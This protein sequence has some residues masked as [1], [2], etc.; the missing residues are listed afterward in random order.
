MRCYRPSPLHAPPC[1]RCFELAAP[2][3]PRS[4]ATARRSSLG[5]VVCAPPGPYVAATHRARPAR[6]VSRR[7]CSAARRA[8]ALAHARQQRRSLKCMLSVLQRCAGVF[9]PREPCARARSLTHAFKC[10]QHPAHASH[11]RARTRIALGSIYVPAW[12][13]ARCDTPLA[14]L[15]SQVPQQALRH[16]LQRRMQHKHTR[17]NAYMLPRC[18]PARIQRALG[19]ETRINTSPHTTHKHPA[20][21]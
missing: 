1:T 18:V 3:P 17:K 4:L 5:V 11:A 13:P 8:A 20:T 12:R 6:A 9:R 15:H 16:T 14:T 2:R 10:V 19:S 21:R 7:T